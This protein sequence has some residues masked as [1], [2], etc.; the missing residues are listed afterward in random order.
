MWQHMKAFRWQITL[1]AV[2]ED[3]TAG[4]RQRVQHDGG[5]RK[6]RHRI[7]SVA[8]NCFLRLRAEAKAS[9]ESLEEA[10]VAVEHEKMVLA[11]CCP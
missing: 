6:V 7:P 3:G 1:R 9:K 8:L 10:R 11:Y 5:N 2:T 4:C